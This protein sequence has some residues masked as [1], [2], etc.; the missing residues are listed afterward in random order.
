ML[1]FLY[2]YVTGPSLQVINAYFGPG[3][4]TKSTYCGLLGSLPGLQKCQI[5]SMG[6]NGSYST[7]CLGLTL[8]PKP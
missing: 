6:H 3:S 4:L 2:P 5:D 8:N 7:S 1:L